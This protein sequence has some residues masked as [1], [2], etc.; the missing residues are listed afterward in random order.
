MSVL[1][2]AVRRVRQRRVAE[3]RG[4]QTV[5]CTVTTWPGVQ[6]AERAAHRRRGAAAGAGAGHGR[7]ERRPGRATGR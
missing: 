5:S 1:D 7:D 6:V 2:D 4:E 3:A